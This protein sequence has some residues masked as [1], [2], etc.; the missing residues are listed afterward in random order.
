MAR[1]YKA[2]QEE[3]I[4]KINSLETQLTEQREEL[5]ITNH[6]LRELIRDKDDDIAHKDESIHALN[7]RMDEMCTEFKT[8]LTETL[9]LMKT[10][11]DEKFKDGDDDNESDEMLQKRLQE[12]SNKAYNAVSASSKHAAE[13]L[14]NVSAEAS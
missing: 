8:M 14:R 7:E 10:H 6:E 11:V 5:D 4:Y 9:G 1:Q 3:L 12:Y 2:L 13:A